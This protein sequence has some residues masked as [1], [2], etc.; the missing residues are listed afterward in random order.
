MSANLPRP[1]LHWENKGRPL[2]AVGRSGYK[3]GELNQAHLPLE[4]SLQT[5]TSVGE[6]VQGALIQGEAGEVVP[7]LPSVLARLGLPEEVRLV[8]L[9]PPFNTGRQFDHYSDALPIDVWLS[10]ISTRLES[11]LPLLCERSSVWLHIDSANSHLARCL[12]D[13]VFGPEAFVS[14]ITWQKRRTRESRTPISDSHDHIHVYAPAGPK[15]WKKYRNRL[16]RPADSVPN[17][18][19][20]PRGPWMDAPFTAPGI[21][22]NQLYDIVTPSGSVIRP[23]EGRCWY[24][25][26]PVFQELLA[27]NRIWFP[28]GGAGSPRIK[29]FIDELDGLVPSSLWLAEEVGGND[30]AKRHLQSMSAGGWFDTPKPESLLARI[31]HIA[32]DEGDLVLDPFAGSGTTAAAAH[33]LDRTWITIERLA[34]VAEDVTL[35]RLERVVQGRD[36]GGISAAIEWSGGGGFEFLT[37]EA[38]QLAAEVA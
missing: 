36:P 19:N 3:W 10:L 24:A 1:T 15:A 6:G 29:R 8:Y 9:D 30:D 16:P 33:K 7:S 5:V 38:S 14:S 31:I 26:E 27:D 12:M 37:A 35:P 34:E 2:V 11:M 20:D 32:S 23:P 13:E 25:T 17:R 4:P 22:P 28:R 21:R 18:D